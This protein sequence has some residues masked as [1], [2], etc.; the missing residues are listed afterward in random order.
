MPFRCAKP[1]SNVF[2]FLVPFLVYITDSKNGILQN[3]LTDRNFS[4]GPP[5]IHQEVIAFDQSFF[6]LDCSG[7]KYL[8]Y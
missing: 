7:K 3:T 2:Y 5:N 4:Q 8:L 6:S 1:S